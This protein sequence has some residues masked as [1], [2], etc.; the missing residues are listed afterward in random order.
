M[1]IVNSFEE[2]MKDAELPGKTPKEIF[3]QLLPLTFYYL[4]CSLPFDDI[5]QI[6]AN[7]CNISLTNHEIFHMIFQLSDPILRGFCIEHYSFSNPVPFY[8]PILSQNDKTISFKPTNEL[9]YSMESFNGLI[10]FGIGRAGWNQMG[11][12]YLLDLTFG[13]D[14]VNASPQKSAFHSGS[15]DIQMT[16][17]LFGE[18]V[19]DKSESTKWAYLDCQGNTKFEVINAISQHLDIALVHISYND[20]INRGALLENDILKSTQTVKRAY[21]LIRDY[22]ETE[23]KR[24]EEDFYIH[25]SAKLIFV[26]NLTNTNINIQSVKKRL[27]EIGHEILHQKSEKN[28]GGKFLESVLDLKHERLN[29]IRSDNQLVMKIKENIISETKESDKLNFSSFNYYPLFV[30]YMNCFYKSC[31]ETDQKLIDK[32][33]GERQLLNTQILK[34]DKGEVVDHFNQILD[35]NRSTLILWKLSQELSQLSN[36]LFPKSVIEQNKE[37]FTLEILWRETL[38]YIKYGNLGLREADHFKR[39]IASNYSKHVE[40]GEA[41]ELIDGDNLSY[42]DKE[43]D[44]LLADVYEMNKGKEAPIVVSIFGPQSSGKSTLLNYCF[45][46]K[47]LTSAGR[48]TRGIYGS[49][50]RLSRKVN[51][52]HQLLILDTEGLDAI[53]RKT[54]MN[55]IEKKSMQ[56]TSI[57]H[58]DR[59]MVLFCLAVSQVVI[60]NVKGDIG[61]QMQNMLQIC[62]YA[63]NKLKVRKVPPPKIFFVLNQQADPDPEKHLESINILMN[64]INRNPIC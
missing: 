16:K 34:Q 30:K 39:K 18:K 64:N 28:I 40:M 20:Y 50:S 56:D 43:I 8:Y 44:S 54:M 42:F 6:L 37:K 57:I 33:N 63:L 15:I 48:C 25:K 4:K 12:S 60:I 13:T 49:L 7:T 36:E 3:Q 46:C 27:R 62:A 26:P 1:V 61:S 32:L 41:F 22:N 52:A 59:T 35:T 11:K 29:A 55:D 58:F 23:L 2:I 14:F 45:G 38:L 24:Q 21:F 17:N 47:F 9:W 51:G 53:E 10:S 5:T 31:Y 19:E